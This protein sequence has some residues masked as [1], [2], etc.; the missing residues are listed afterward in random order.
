M[1]HS[2]RKQKTLK[3]RSRNQNLGIRQGDMKKKQQQKIK[4]NYKQKNTETRK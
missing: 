2:T 3:L 1:K 4:T